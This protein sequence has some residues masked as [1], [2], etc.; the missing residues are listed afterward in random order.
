MVAAACTALHGRKKGR[1]FSDKFLNRIGRYVV[2]AEV[3]RP[4][5]I[6]SSGGKSVFV[7]QALAK[8]YQAHYVFVGERKPY[9]NRGL[10]V[11]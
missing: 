3:A 7:A 8:R 5:I 2:P 4:D 6:V 1:A 10:T 11:L 9:L